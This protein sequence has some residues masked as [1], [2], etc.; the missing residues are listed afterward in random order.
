MSDAFGAATQQNLFTGGDGAKSYGWNLLNSAHATGADVNITNPG[1][2]SIY[3]IGVSS[4]TGATFTVPFVYK[5]LSGDFDVNIGTNSASYG[6][7]LV[8][9]DPASSAGGSG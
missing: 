3:P 5:N 4:P 7:G 6:M 1:Y 8:A 2:L 9:Y